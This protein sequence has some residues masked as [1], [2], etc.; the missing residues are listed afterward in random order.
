MNPWTSV[1][2]S[3]STDGIEGG[4]E[5]G[6]QVVHGWPALL[7]G[8]LG[9]NIRRR[10]RDEQRW[11]CA[12]FP[13]YDNSASTCMN[14]KEWH[15]GNWLLIDHWLLLWIIFFC[16]IIEDWFHALTHY[17][18]KL[19]LYWCQLVY[20]Y[21]LIGMKQSSMKQILN[22]KDWQ[23]K[24]SMFLLPIKNSKWHYLLW[25]PNEPGQTNNHTRNK[26]LW[27]SECSATIGRSIALMSNT[28]R[29]FASP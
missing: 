29:S 5:G 19:C 1:P 15:G 2:L 10:P 16:C 6:L 14:P 27:R 24:L 22:W 17:L 4:G 12:S 25:M 23:S 20:L 28:M 9:L 3:P 8:L 18:H 13:F 7:T 11:P 26:W 21:D